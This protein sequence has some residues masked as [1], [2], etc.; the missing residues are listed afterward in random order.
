MCIFTYTYLVYITAYLYRNI[1]RKYYNFFPNANFDLEIIYLFIKKHTHH[2]IEH[3]L[4]A[5][6]SFWC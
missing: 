6:N 4:C 1:K 2:I 5:R 3:F